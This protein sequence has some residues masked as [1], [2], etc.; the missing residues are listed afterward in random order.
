MERKRWEHYTHCASGCFLSTLP[1][2][3]LQRCPYREGERD[4]HNNTSLWACSVYVS[5]LSSADKRWL[6]AEQ[7]SQER[8]GNTR[9]RAGGGSTR[10]T[11]GRSRHGREG[12][13]GREKSARTQ[14][15]HGIR[16]S[17]VYI[18]TG[19]RAPPHP[20]GSHQRRHT[21]A[22]T[23]SACRWREQRDGGGWERGGGEGGREAS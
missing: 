6:C 9:V 7:A 5:L 11:R 2:L 18:T 8:D 4:Q 10:T 23:S 3:S 15:N 21:R 17:R 19:T 14:T 20:Q 13:L 22:V 12:R 16:T 1:V